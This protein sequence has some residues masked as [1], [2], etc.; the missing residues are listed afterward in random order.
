[1]DPLN[2]YNFAI[3]CEEHEE[4]CLDKIM[5]G[6]FRFEVDIDQANFDRNPY[7]EK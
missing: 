3:L 1:M 5:Y 4:V 2:M 6:Q 7:W